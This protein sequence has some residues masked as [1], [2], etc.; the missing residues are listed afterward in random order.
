MHS[1]TQEHHCD[2]V[3]KAR[4]YPYLLPYLA[5]YKWV[6]FLDEDLSLSSFDLRCFLKTVSKE[7]A[8]P[9]KPLLIVQPTLYENTQIQAS[10]SRN[11]WFKKDTNEPIYP[12]VI[13]G[14]HWMIE[15]QMPMF[16]AS[17]LEWFIEFVIVPLKRPRAVLCNDWG[18]EASWC[19]AAFHYAR[20]V[21][22][23]NDTGYFPC[24]VV[25]G[26]NLSL[27]HFNTRSI[28]M[29][30]MNTNLFV[31][32]GKESVAVYNKVFPKL[33]NDNSRI[34]WI[35]KNRHSDEFKPV[36][37]HNASFSC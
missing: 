7:A 34:D 16:D 5:M 1:D 30:R 19:M 33:K 25:V 4:L 27:H 14:V 13:L 28:K 10:Y 18:M 32:L 22:H 6:W 15:Q 9:K 2:F 31:E 37:I 23:Y 20:N 11:F 29:R 12:N 26:K 21:L 24:G 17:F 35:F 8:N 3:A 36:F